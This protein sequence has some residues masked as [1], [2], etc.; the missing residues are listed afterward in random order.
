MNDWDLYPP[1]FTKPMTITQFDDGLN[2]MIKYE[3]IWY[4][5]GNWMG[6]LKLI[7]KDKN[8]IIHSISSWKVQTKSNINN[9][10]NIR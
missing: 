9:K 3:N 2:N 8:T 7:N 10:N 5:C 6:K 4:V 1:D